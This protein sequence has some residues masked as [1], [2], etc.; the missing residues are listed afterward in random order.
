MSLVVNDSVHTINSLNS[1]PQN[2]NLKE[3]N[4]SEVKNSNLELNENQ[5]LLGSE[6]VIEN[7]LASNTNSLGS[8]LKF[9]SKDIIGAQND[10]S[11]IEEQKL[12]LKSMKELAIKGEKESLDIDG[13][14]YINEEFN[15]LKSEIDNLADRSEN[16]LNSGELGKIDDT[17]ASLTEIDLFSIENAQKAASVIDNSFTQLD[18]L[19]SDLISIEN[20]S[21]ISAKEQI[22]SQLNQHT[23]RNEIRDID[24]A[25]ES[26]SFSKTQLLEQNGDYKL[27][28]ANVGSDQVYS[29]LR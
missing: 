21:I 25:K 9:L 1:E 23:L 18:T 8:I 11:V 14:R 3:L 28:Q 27:A 6:K 13:R 5:E 24:F 19:Q 2:R 20:Q 7:K 16:L 22:E 12:V 4:H 26:E 17:T 15:T 29:L 10:S